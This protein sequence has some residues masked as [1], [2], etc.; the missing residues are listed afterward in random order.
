MEGVTPGLA[1][2]PSGEEVSLEAVQLAHYEPD[3]PHEASPLRARKQ[4]V[5]VPVVHQSRLPLFVS[6]QD[7]E[8]D[9]V[10]RVARIGVGGPLQE[11][12]AAPVGV[13]ASVIGVL[14]KRFSDDVWDEQ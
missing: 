9:Q 1:P 7:R 12:H 5:G 2:A 14:D 6:N 13:V 4:A 8:V 10:G 11:A 3:L